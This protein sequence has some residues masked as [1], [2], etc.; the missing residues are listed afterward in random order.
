M[1]RVEWITM[2]CEVV[3]VPGEQTGRC[4]GSLR[5]EEQ[6]GFFLQ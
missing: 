3:A 6:V 1:Q 4:T 5:W 2:A